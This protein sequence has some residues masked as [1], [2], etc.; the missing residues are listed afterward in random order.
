MAQSALG[1]YEL[2]PA[3]RAILASIWPSRR[4]ARCATSFESTGRTPWPMARAQ[5]IS[6]GSISLRCRWAVGRIS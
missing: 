6:F 1:P 5:P 4:C 3:P 2:R